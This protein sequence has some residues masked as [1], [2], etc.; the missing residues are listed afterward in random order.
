MNTPT[1][2]ETEKAK[3][4]YI[5]HKLLITDNTKYVKRGQALII[6][7]DPQRYEEVMSANRNKAGALFQYAESLFAVLAVVKSITGLPYRCLQRLADTNNYQTQSRSSADISIH[8]QGLYYHIE[9][10]ISLSHDVSKINMHPTHCFLSRNFVCYRCHHGYM[11]GSPSRGI[12]LSM[13][14]PHTSFR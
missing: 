14:M 8:E 12:V 10:G 9:S 4:Q 13:Y 1:S 6:R 5:R 3:D 7:D 11:V 2:S